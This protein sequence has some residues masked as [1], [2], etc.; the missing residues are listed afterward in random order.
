MSR[1]REYISTNPLRWHLDRENPF[2]V[3]EDDLWNNLFIKEVA[4]DGGTI[5]ASRRLALGEI[6][7]GGEDIQRFA[8]A[9]REGI[10]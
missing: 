8:S 3:G 9:A 6:G 7:G 2:R 10:F 5:Q 4:D 1:I